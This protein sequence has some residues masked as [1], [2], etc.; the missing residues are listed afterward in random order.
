MSLPGQS[1][2][3]MTNPAKG[4][5]SQSALDFQAKI[6]PNVLYDLVAGQ[7][8]HINSA[9]ELE[10]GVQLHQM[11]LFMFQGANDYDVNNE[12]NSQW[13]P[14]SPSGRVMCLVATGAYE[15]ETT[16]FDSTQSY[17]TNDFL[18]APIGNSSGS[19]GVSGVLTNV[20]ASTL[21]TSNMIA[22]VGIVSRGAFTNCYGVSVISFWPIFLPGRV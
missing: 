16:A 5:P 4:W 19:A 1:F 20:D 9:G 8:A 15:L 12:R 7:C 18:N 10:P 22:K 17:N 3:N 14:I 2:T 13:T 21:Y 6:S 11:G